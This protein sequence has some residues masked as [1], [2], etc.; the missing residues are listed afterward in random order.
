MQHSRDFSA[1]ASSRWLN[2]PGSVVAVR[3]YE[4]RGSSA[5]QEGTAAHQLGEIGLKENLTDVE[6]QTYVGK[7]LS[8]APDV[9]IDKDMVDYIQGY[10]DYCRS[11]QGDHFVE[12]QVSYEHVVGGGFG[13]SDFIA[14]DPLSK[15]VY[16]I[17]LKYGKGFEVSA[18][19]NTQAQL[20]ALGVVNEYSFLYD[21]DD[22]WQ[23]EMHIYQPRIGNFSE[24]KISFNELMLFSDHVRKQAELSKK[25]DAPFVPGEKQCQ[26][27]AHK[28]NCTA[29]YKHTEQVISAEFDDLDNLPTPDCVDVQ[30]VLAN[31]KLIESWLKAVEQN[32][33]E[34]LTNGEKLPGF[35]LVAGRSSRKWHDES[36]ARSELLADG[37]SDDELQTRKFLSVAQAEKLIGKKDFSA[38][39]ELVNKSEGKPTL[40]PES[41]T[42]PPLD[43]V[44]CDFE[45]I[46]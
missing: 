38:F 46:S 19:D 32:A 4:N 16:C 12:V 28:A 22:S 9:V 35:K 34:K 24:W 30:K 25:P 27:C 42:R 21:F 15:T 10:V 20:Y 11:F 45:N 33:F 29:L 39:D 26:W 31:K 40:V 2:C 6:L 43:D 7:Y 14:V 17:D 13:T 41:D 44:S 37:Y 36:K 23:I 5:A 8:D 1:S 3:Q 18:V